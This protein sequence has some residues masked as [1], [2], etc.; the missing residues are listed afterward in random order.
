M[1]RFFLSLLGVLITGWVISMPVLAI[2]ETILNR[3]LG[4][5]SHPNELPMI[6]ESQSASD[7]AA[8]YGYEISAIEVMGLLPKSDDPTTGFVGD[9]RGKPSLPPE[10]Y[11]VYPGPV[12]ETLKMAGIPAVAL[13]GATIETLKEAIT[14]GHPVICWVVGRTARGKAEVY[15]TEAGNEVIVA[16]QMNTVT[17]DG[18]NETGFSVWDNGENYFRT[19]RDFED[20]WKILGYQGLQIVVN[21]TVSIDPETTPEPKDAV[22]LE[23][24]PQGTAI[25]LYAAPTTAPETPTAETPTAEAWA[26]TQTD[27]WNAG[28]DQYWQSSKES[29]ADAGLLSTETNFWMDE[30]FARFGE[31]PTVEPIFGDAAT[32]PI[33][34][35]YETWFMESGSDSSANVWSPTI[36]QQS[37][38]DTNAN[39]LIPPSAA[40]DGFVGYAQSYNLDCE[41]R[42]AI[43]LA[44]YFGVKIDYMSFLNGLPK[45]DDPNE[46][47]VG[48]YWDA[49]GGLPPNGYG[50]YERPIAEQLSRFG[51]PAVGVANFTWEMVKAQLS[52]GNPVMAWVVGNTTEGTPLSYTP[53]NGRTTAVVP[54]QHTV[55][56]V[57]YDETAGTVSLQDGGMRYTRGIQTF[58]NSWAVLGNR[59]VFRQD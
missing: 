2:D 20:S 37:G 59:A 3:I 16:R 14:A 1:K 10:S 11:G 4:Y 5:V 42:S 57:G 23:P 21:S 52:I 47:F 22:G 45:S 9:P 12:V 51:L 53:A 50:V 49:R 38:M 35:G 31:I 41:T 18:F 58:L 28:Q 24:Y 34:S 33:L 17:V 39:G 48:N 54:Y 32:G 26:G 27:W 40:I 30:A 36:W 29:L 15:Q 44:S 13:S 7:L 43:D 6:S 25:P 46:G 56:V 19:F 55:V 8:F